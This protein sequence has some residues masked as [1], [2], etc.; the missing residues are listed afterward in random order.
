MQSWKLLTILAVLGLFFSGCASLA[1]EGE[2]RHLLIIHEMNEFPDGYT[3]LD[4]GFANTEYLLK[5]ADSMDLE[6]GRIYIS[7]EAITSETIRESLAWAE[8]NRDAGDPL[9]FYIGT[10]G[11]Y[12]RRGLGWRYWFPEEWEKVGGPKAVIIDSCNSEEFLLPLE[13]QGGW[14]LAGCR[15]DELSWWGVPEEGLPILGSVWLYYL[16]EALEAPEGDG[17]RDG[18]ISLEESFAYAAPRLQE[19]IQTKVLTNPEWLA[20]MH[21]HGVFP[22]RKETYPNPVLKAGEGEILLSRLAP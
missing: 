2:P 7:H 6:E 9:L 13:S 4:T 10:H 15:R 11:S 18:W 1:G 21:G 19:Y 3:D 22:E 8:A 5:M 14:A 16:T 17:N 20:S 12:L